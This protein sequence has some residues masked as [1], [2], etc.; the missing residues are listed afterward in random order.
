MPNFMLI[1]RFLSAFIALLLYASTAS[2]QDF[3]NQPRASTN[4]LILTSSSIN[5]FKTSVGN[6]GGAKVDPSS[7]T[8]TLGGKDVTSITDITPSRGASY[9]EFYD[10]F[11]FEIK[12]TDPIKAQPNLEVKLTGLTKDGIPFE[13]KTVAGVV[14]KFVIAPTHIIKIPSYDSVLEDATSKTPVSVF[15]HDAV[16][17]LYQEG[18]E[19]ENFKFEVSVRFRS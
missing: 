1:S 11:N 3:P 13:S 16:S 18:D 17:I 5:G 19:L 12:L 6:F 9:R 8:L 10:G 2:A 15:E 7:L 14:A 4:N